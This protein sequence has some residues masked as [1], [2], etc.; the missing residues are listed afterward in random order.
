[1]IIQTSVG[2]FGN[3]KDIR[4]HM[5]VHDLQTIEIY[6]VVYWGIPVLSKGFYTLPQ[7]DFIINA[8]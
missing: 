4:T 6:S 5:I 8:E 3:F 1:M 7:I 2:E